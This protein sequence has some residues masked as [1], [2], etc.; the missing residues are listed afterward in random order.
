MPEYTKLT[1]INVKGENLNNYYVKRIDNDVFWD[2]TPYK[3]VDM[4]RHLG[5]QITG[6]SSLHRLI[7]ISLSREQTVDYLEYY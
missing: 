6:V 4:Y 1:T 2:V 5:N 7:F 3:L